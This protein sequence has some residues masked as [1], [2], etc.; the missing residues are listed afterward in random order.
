MR[1]SSIILF[2]LLSFLRL[3]LIEVVKKVCTQKLPLGKKE[4]FWPFFG[5]FWCPEVTLVTFNSNL[6]NFLKNKKSHNFF[7]FFNPKRNTFLNPTGVPWARRS[8]KDTRKSLC[9]ILDR[10]GFPDKTRPDQSWIRNIASQSHVRF[11]WCFSLQNVNTI[12]FLPKTNFNS[13]G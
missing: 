13:F 2:N 3:G 7:F 8:P 1:F 5:H 9:L 11:R 6:S 12:F 4:L 10:S